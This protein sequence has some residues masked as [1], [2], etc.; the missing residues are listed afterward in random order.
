MALAQH[1][2]RLRSP[3]RTPTPTVTSSP[4]V[5]PTTHPGIRTCTASAQSPTP[6][7]IRA[8]GW[9]ADIG[10]LIEGIDSLHPELDHRRPSRDLNS[11]AN[12]ISLRYRRDR[13]PADGRVMRIVAMVSAKVRR[14]HRG[15]RLGRRQLSIPACRS[16]SGC[17]VTTSTWWMRPT[18]RGPGRAANRELNGRPIS[19]VIAHRS[20]RAARQRRD[21]SIAYAALPPEHS[22]PARLGL[23]ILETITLTTSG[24]DGQARL[25]M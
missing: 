3:S 4:S 22:D 11:A 23:T 6:M 5:A 2:R 21:H 1:R 7:P 20:D 19:D 10:H 17:S 15:L 18:V 9:R 8:D 16:G 25:R 12:E 14:S 24:D 13:R